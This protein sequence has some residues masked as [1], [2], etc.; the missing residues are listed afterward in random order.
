MKIF[1]NASLRG[2]KEFEKQYASII[3]A[4]RA[5]GHNLLDSPVLRSDL[6]KVARESSQEAE[7][8][9]KSLRKHLTS[10][11]IAIFEV[12]FSST[13]IGHE[14]T[15]AMEH[16][17]PVIAFYYKG[18]NPYLLESIVNDRL[19]V[20]EYDIENISDELSKALQY[21]S[22]QQDTRFNFFIPPKIAHYLDWI[23]RYRKMPRAVYLRK[24]I[25]LDMQ[26]RSEEPQI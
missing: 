7:A 10:S 13:G 16:G 19:Q 25:E 4:L 2:K 22:E 12:S 5:T 24:L 21:A 18:H 9:Y 3:E 17:K 20:I 26:K 23:A 14:I 1:F 8:Y 11:D 15:L 6:D